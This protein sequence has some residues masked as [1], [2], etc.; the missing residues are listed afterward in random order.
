MNKEAVWRKWVCESE[1]RVSAE[2][3]V[4]AYIGFFIFVYYAKHA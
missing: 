2:R 3:R 4:L 1:A